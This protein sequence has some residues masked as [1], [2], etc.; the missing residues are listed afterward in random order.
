[1]DEQ[2]NSVQDYQQTQVITTS[3]TDKT[4]KDIGEMIVGAITT[5]SQIK[6]QGE[7]EMARYEAETAKID[8]EL[9]LEQMKSDERITTTL[10]KWDTYFKGGVLVI[11]F[12]SIISIQYL[13]G[14]SLT[15]TIVPVV[16]FILGS[17]FKNTINDFVKVRTKKK[18]QTNLGENEDD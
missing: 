18:R 6:Q 3:V 17:V 11:S 7:V 16:T 15:A 2:N 10:V 14:S 8:E 4:I 1:M 13:G 5:M 9:Y 12:G